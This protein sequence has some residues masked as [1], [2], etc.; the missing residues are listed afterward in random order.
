MNSATF[1]PPSVV[2]ATIARM[3]R[4]SMLTKRG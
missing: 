4:E 3:I 1:S 2:H